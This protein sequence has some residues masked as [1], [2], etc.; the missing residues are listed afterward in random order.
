MAVRLT[1][2]ESVKQTRRRLLD[3][4]ETLFIERG[5]HAASLDA[6]AERAGFSKGAVYSRFD[7]KADLFLALLEE[8]NPRIV[9]AFADLLAEAGSGADLIGA[10]GRWWV[11]RMREGSAW[12]LVLV[13]FWTSAGRDPALRERF[14]QSHERLMLALAKRTDDAAERLGVQLAVSSLDLARITTALGRGLQLERLLDPGAVD[15]ATMSWAF[16]SF[17]HPRPELLDETS[18][19]PTGMAT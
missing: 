2:G 9:E 13:E 14:A 15:E 6:V 18:T 17:A 5:F 19:P 7:H 8:R 4:A 1:R 12:S 10:F 16:G 3:A 11:E